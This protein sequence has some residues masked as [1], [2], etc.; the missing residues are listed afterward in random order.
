MEKTPYAI[1]RKFVPQPA[2]VEQLK[3]ELEPEYSDGEEVG[4]IPEEMATSSSSSNAYTSVVVGPSRAMPRD[5]CWT[6]AG[7]LVWWEETP[8]QFVVAQVLHCTKSGK[9]IITLGRGGLKTVFESELTLI[10]RH[11]KPAPKR[12]GRVLRIGP[13]GRPILAPSTERPA[14]RQRRRFFEILSNDLWKVVL[15]FSQTK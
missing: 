8:N 5:F 7:D 13:D 3:P 14:V 1:R 10:H 4:V 2:N 9:W 6:Q 11:E 12:P 15:G